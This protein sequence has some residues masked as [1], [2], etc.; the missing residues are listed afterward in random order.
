MLLISFLKEGLKMNGII[1]GAGIAGLSTAIA[2]KLKGI[3]VDIYEASAE[4]KAIGAGILI[5]PNAMAVLDH[6]GLADEVK[7]SGKELNALQVANFRGEPI[8][9]TPSTYINN[10]T[11]FKTVALH[12]GELQSLLLRHINKERIH[13]GFQ[14]SGVKNRNDDVQVFFNNDHQRTADFVIGADGLRSKVR[15][16]VMPDSA[17]RNAQQICWRGVA[18]IQLPERWDAQLTEFWGHGTRFG[19]V[20]IGPNQ[21]YWYATVSTKPHYVKPGRATK[22]VREIFSSY[23]KC[24]GDILDSTPQD[25]I[26]EGSLYDIEPLQHWFSKRAV[27]IG[28]AA[29][30]ITP[31]LG[32]GGALAIE[33]SYDIAEKM[34]RYTDPTQAFAKF[35]Q[36]RQPR[37]NRVSKASWNIGQVSNWR[38][39]LLC[40]T[41]NQIISRFAPMMAKRQSDWLYRFEV[42]NPSH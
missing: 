8:S 1:I 3:D 22:N 16:L 21:V 41:R 28:D 19:F 12:R 25:L 31:N 9:T 37:V 17:L 30:A 10:Q 20:P 36:S 27:L 34:A 14:C 13:L 42:S 23:I 5:P 6:S 11:P 38:S 32:Q 33:D 2:L 18:N 35:Q 29:H 7:S 4:L 39:P 40:S 24:V 15:Q 26:I